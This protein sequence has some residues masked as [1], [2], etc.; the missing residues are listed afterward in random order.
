MHR[1]IYFSSATH[2]LTD[3][4]LHLLLDKSRIKNSQ[5]DISG[6]LIHI[7]GDILQ[8]LEGEKEKIQNLFELIK[9]DPKHSTIIKVFDNEVPTRMFENWSMGFS[10]E[11][12]EN[13][14]KNSNLC[15]LSI[16]ELQENRGN[17]VT[18]FLETFIKTHK[19]T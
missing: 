1:I 7:D 6:I 17:I 4:E 2:L 3:N 5:N 10:K 16:K 8:V 18:G 19:I 15:W 12:I 11:T 13:V 14:R 9:L